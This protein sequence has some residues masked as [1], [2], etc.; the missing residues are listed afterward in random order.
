MSKEKVI[1]KISV[2][3]LLAGA[4]ICT[5]VLNENAQKAQAATD[6]TPINTVA[7]V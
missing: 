1:K 6:E 5:N 7:T 4:M 3:A 2:S